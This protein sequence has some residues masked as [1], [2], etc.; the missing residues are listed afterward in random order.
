MVLKKLIE[1]ETMRDSLNFLLNLKT[2]QKNSFVSP[3]DF[4]A[5]LDSNEDLVDELSEIALKVLRYPETIND[6]QSL[7]YTD[8]VISKNNAISRLF[9]L[10][11]SSEANPLEK[12]ISKQTFKDM[13]K[14]IQARRDEIEERVKI[15]GAHRVSKVLLQE[16]ANE[17][18]R[19]KIGL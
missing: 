5:M 7:A 3:A 11:S 13:L 14:L 4:N 15:A 8:R 12:S 6:A 10:A 18:A 9:E 1:V 17:E 2:V 19:L 16:L